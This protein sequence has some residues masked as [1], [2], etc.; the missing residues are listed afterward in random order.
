MS[1]RTP[2]A[3]ALGALALLARPPAEAATA[4]GPPPLP[5]PEGRL[6]LLAGNAHATNF[7]ALDQSART[8]A[9]ADAWIYT[10]SAHP[11]ALPPHKDDPPRIVV[12]TFQ[13]LRIDCAARRTRRLRVTGYDAAGEALLTLRPDAEARWI[14]AFSTEH[15]AAKTL[16]DGA[17]LP[18]AY[19]VVG[20]DTALKTARVLFA[21]Q[22]DRDQRQLRRR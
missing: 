12:Q 9:V 7:V 16:C 3:A 21:R 17:R 1:A 6:M 19:V 14:D 13:H 20:H 15:F 11:I 2:L 10:A 18:G 22:A 4:L 8:G 5:L